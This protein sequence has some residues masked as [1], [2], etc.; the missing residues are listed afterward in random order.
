M[1]D[2][3][4]TRPEVVGRAL[5]AMCPHGIPAARVAVM[6]RVQAYLQAAADVLAGVEPT[7][8]MSCGVA[9]TRSPDA[10]RK[11][12]RRADL[13]RTDAA[14]RRRRLAGEL[15]DPD[16]HPF[17]LVPDR[18]I[19]LVVGCDAKTATEWR[20][21]HGRAAP[22]NAGYCP[23]NEDRWAAAFNA[24][25]EE[26]IRE[27]LRR[28]AGRADARQQLRRFEEWLAAREVKP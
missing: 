7:L 11:A 8:P 21:K 15:G 19:A 3:T 25:G 26:R 12:E 5:E 24:W 28:F 2:L 13:R 27:W 4:I 23:T 22:P 9:G 17:G 20:I 10:A 6:P 1:D 14:E 18:V 16:A